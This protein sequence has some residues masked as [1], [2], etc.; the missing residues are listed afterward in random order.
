[1][2][3]CP[4]P[5]AGSPEWTHI[6]WNGLAEAW[7]PIRFPVF[8]RAFGEESCLRVDKAFARHERTSS[9]SARRASVVL[10]CSLVCG[11]E[12]RVAARHP[13]SYETQFLEMSVRLPCAVVEMASL[14]RFA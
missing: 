14:G 2:P 10:R 12:S 7:S 4:Q 13:P 8:V 3:S 6:T 5:S 9:P 1:M 11:L